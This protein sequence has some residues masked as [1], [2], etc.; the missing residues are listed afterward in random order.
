[1][2][3]FMNGQCCEPLMMEQW[4]FFTPRKTFLRKCGFLFFFSFLFLF[5]ILA[6]NIR[7][8]AKSAKHTNYG[9]SFFFFFY[10]FF[11]S[12]LFFQHFFPL[13]SA[14]KGLFFSYKQC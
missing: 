12:S 1:M 13:G 3:Y 11:F 7:L 9:L 10:F 2:V 4:P 6:P 14:Y 8:V 5:S